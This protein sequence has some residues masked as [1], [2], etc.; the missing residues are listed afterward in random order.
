[1]NY[2]EK[3]K[4]EIEEFANRIVMSGNDISEKQIKKSD[5]DKTLIGFVSEKIERE[6]GS[7]RWRIQTNGT[8][9]DVAPEM[10]NITEVGQRVRLY[11]PNHSFKDKYAEVIDNY[12]YTHPDKA[13]Y[14]DTTDDITETWKMNDSTLE[15]RVFHL[16]IVNKNTSE[17]SV[18]AIH[19]PDGSVMSLEGF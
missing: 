4:S 7:Y 10:S 3:L 19:F 16:D 18:T 11:V 13:V 2:D 1:M 5:F 14:D 6:D 9:Y 12:C 17:E 15:T 8:A